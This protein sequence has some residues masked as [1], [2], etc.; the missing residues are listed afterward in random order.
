MKL[1]VPLLRDLVMLALGSGV[2]IQEIWGRPAPEPLGVT[3]S[4]LLLGGPA[5]INTWWLARNPQPTTPPV[6]PTPSPQ[7]SLPPSSSSPS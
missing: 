1:T 4:L 7:P 3:V 5:A 2:M 6:A